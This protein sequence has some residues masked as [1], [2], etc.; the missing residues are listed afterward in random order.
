MECADIENCRSY[1]NK[2]NMKKAIERFGFTK[3]R[4]MTVYNMAGRCTPIFFLDRT[5]GGY[6]GYFAQAGFMTV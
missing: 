3:D 2:A 5:R 4:Y 6:A 1:A